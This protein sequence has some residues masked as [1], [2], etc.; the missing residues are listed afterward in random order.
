MLMMLA[1]L[2]GSQNAA[3][4]AAHDACLLGG[5]APAHARDEYLGDQLQLM[6]MLPAAFGDGL[7]LMLMMPPALGHGLTLPLRSPSPNAAGIMSIS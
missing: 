6:L 1:S 5:P 4:P 7:L 3:T 2:R